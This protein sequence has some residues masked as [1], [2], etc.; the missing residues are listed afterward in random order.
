MF[1]YMP[2][3]PI[4]TPSSLEHSSDKMKTCQRNEVPLGYW[5]L[6]LHHTE[7]SHDEGNQIGH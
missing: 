4:V 5:L 3:Y 6:S 7:V 1:L 2:H